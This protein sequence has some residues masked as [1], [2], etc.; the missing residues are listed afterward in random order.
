MHESLSVQLL[1][2]TAPVFLAFPCLC[3]F[4][5]LSTDLPGPFTGCFPVALP[6][7]LLAILLRPRAVPVPLRPAALGGL[8][9]D[10]PITIDIEEDSLWKDWTMV[11][12]RLFPICSAASFLLGTREIKPKDN[13]Q[14]QH[15]FLKIVTR[16]I[17]I[18]CF[19]PYRF[20]PRKKES[21]S[22]IVN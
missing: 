3:F 22:W 12:F 6:A 14:Q 18:E 1:R 7:P 11:F 16:T 13:L 4:P 17:P 15:N 5:L 10:T 20:Y 21:V 2:L 19:I 9:S 8:L